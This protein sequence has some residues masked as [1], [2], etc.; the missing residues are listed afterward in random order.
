MYP[1]AVS[2]GYAQGG[3]SIPP[4]ILL[5]RLRRAG[6]ADMGPSS[7]ALSRPVGGPLPLTI[8]N[9]R[10]RMEQCGC[11]VGTSSMPFPRTMHSGDR[12]A[13][14]PSFPA[15]S[16]CS[17]SSACLSRHGS[18]NRCGSGGVGQRHRI[19]RSSGASTSHALR[20]NTPFVFSSKRWDG[21]R[22]ACA[23]PNKPIAGPGSCCWRI[24]SYA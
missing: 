24:P 19:W 10:T 16:S 2:Y 1:W 12:M 22:H 6:H 15:R 7:P 17:K 9:R 8:R 21:R 11:A 3:V 4:P 20:W 5:R 23:I 13:L 18:Q 14:A